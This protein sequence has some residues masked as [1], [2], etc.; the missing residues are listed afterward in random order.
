M[1]GLAVCW[2]L[3]AIVHSLTTNDHHFDAALWLTKLPCSLLVLQL[4]A[5][6]QII[7]LFFHWLMIHALL[8]T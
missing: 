3:N 4:S 2:S 6:H 5:L 7:I 8:N 1:Y